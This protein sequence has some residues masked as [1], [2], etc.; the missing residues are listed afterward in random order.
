MNIQSIFNRL[1]ADLSIKTGVFLDAPEDLDRQWLLKEA[2][3]LNKDM[4]AWLE[5]TGWQVLPVKSVSELTLAPI[6]PDWLMPLWERFVLT[7]EPRFLGA[8]IQILVFCYKIEQQ[9]NDKQIAAAKAA[10]ISNEED[11]GI[12]E[13]GFKP[14]S[15]ILFDLARN[16]ISTVTYRANWQEIVPSHGPGAVFPPRDHYDRSYFLTNYTSITDYYPID[17]YFAPIASSWQYWLMYPSRF[18]NRVSSDIVARLTFVPKDSRGP[19]TICVHPSEAIW[20]QQGLRNELE[21]RIKWS[22]YG[23][24]INFT[25]QTI[26]QAL[27]RQ[28][29]CDRLNATIDL[30]DASDRLH[31]D[32]VRYLFGDYAYSRLSCCRAT[33]V[34]LDSASCIALKKWAPMGNCLMFPVES[35]VFYAVVVAGITMKHGRLAANHADVYVYGDDIVIPSKYYSA[36]VYALSICGFIPNEKKCYYRGF[37]RESCGVEAYKGQD[38]TPLRLRSDDL[39]TAAGRT[40]LCGL[41]LRARLQGF[42][43]LSSYIYSNVRKAQGILPISNN[44]KT[45]GIFEYRNVELFRLLLDGEGLIRFNRNLHRF[46]VRIRS[47]RARLDRRAKCDWNHLNDALLS[48]AAESSECRTAEYPVP[49]QERLTYGWSELLH[50]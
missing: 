3:A 21:N 47:L 49:Y 28:G 20:I 17:K 12:W 35:L 33:H 18:M 2:P 26:N 7:D 15:T 19:R 1:L 45:Q 13:A 11:L 25:D 4:L 34:Q 6:F 31:K 44:P 22:R 5:T 39:S 40:S 37:Y 27:A 16:I 46:E 50:L 10:Y 29:S 36:A 43:C 42:D 30:R 23:K 8:L 48:L 24:F 14:T 32:L 9:P 38:V 41:A